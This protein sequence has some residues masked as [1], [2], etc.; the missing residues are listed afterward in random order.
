MSSNTPPRLHYA[1][2]IVGTGI[3]ILLSALGLG[4]FALGMLLPAMSSALELNY[5][6]MGIISAVNFV[7]Y[8][9]AVL[10][11]GKLT[12]RFGFRALITV[13]VLIVACAMS[14][15]G[16]SIGFLSVASALLL[17]G[18]GSGL[19]NIPIMGLITH[20]FDSSKRGQAAGT[21]LIGNSLGIILSGALVPALNLSQ[22]N[23]GWRYSWL[24]FFIIALITALIA[25]TILRNSP[26]DK[27][28][29]MVKAG[30]GKQHQQPNITVSLKQTI[31]HIGA[32]YFLFGFTYVIYATFIVTSLIEDYHMNEQTAGQFWLWIGIISLLSGPLFGTLS[33]YIGRRKTL[34]LVF[35]LQTCAYLLVALSKESSYLYLSI[36]LFGLCVWSVPPIITATIAD[37]L[38]TQ[39]AVTALGLVTLFF[40]FG[41]IT[42]PALAGMMAEYQNS[43]AGGFLLAGGCTALA[44][45]LS[46]LLPKTA[47][48]ARYA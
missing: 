23:E 39:K 25:V 18:I 8:L 22:G 31:L 44:V 43:F 10:I 3:L 42:G 35:S 24:I 1:W 29:T 15:V 37:H 46:S 26:A 33:D 32:I 5:G 21:L 16:F 11:A 14:A 6:Q 27:G 34:M 9:L 12:A 7:G 17:L 28:L 47:S 36:L 41:Q 30:N 2:L 20:W 40:S 48:K 4:R 13:G 19:A 38:G 45:A